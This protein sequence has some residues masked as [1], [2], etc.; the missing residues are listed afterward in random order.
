MQDDEASWS[1]RSQHRLVDD[2]SH[3]VHLERPDLFIAAVRSV[4]DSTVHRAA[5]KVQ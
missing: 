5:A 1:S 2:A 4:I 3:Y